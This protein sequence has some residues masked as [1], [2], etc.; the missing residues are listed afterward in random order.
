MRESSS[1]ITESAYRSAP[2]RGARRMLP[3]VMTSKTRIGRSF[4]LQ[5]VNAV[6]SITRRS[7]VMRLAEGDLV[8]ASSP[9]GPASGIGG[10]DAVDAAVGALQH[11]V[12]LDLGGAEGGG[13]VG[14][15]ER[16]A[17]AGG[18]DDDPALLEVA[19]GPTADVGL[20]HLG[21]SMALCTRVGWP[22]RSRASCRASALMTVAS[23]PMWSA[24][25]R[26]MPARLHRWRRARCCRRRRRR[27]SRRRARTGGI[28]DL[29]GD[30]VDGHPVDGLVD[31]RRGE[32]LTRHLQDDPPPAGGAARVGH[33]R[34]SSRR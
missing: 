17:H 4:S 19:H 33:G 32:R 24:V 6:R 20:G 13:R 25:A 1:S 18:E 26:S 9:S 34:L 22:W 11:H 8:V 29:A 15:E 16:V 10:V 23:M 5:S 21:M 2:P 28:G 30:A 14:G 12:G 7:L 27:R 3:G 31:L